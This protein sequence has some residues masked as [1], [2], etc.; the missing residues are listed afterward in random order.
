[1][2]RERTNVFALVVQSEKDFQ[3][4]FCYDRVLYWM[5]KD[6]RRKNGG[7]LFEVQYPSFEIW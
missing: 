4:G 1:M 2:A 3:H 6:P 5:F 7:T